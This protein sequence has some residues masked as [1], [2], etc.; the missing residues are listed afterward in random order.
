MTA[1]PLNGTRLRRHRRRSRHHARSSQT[2][3]PNHLASSRVRWLAQAHGSQVVPRP[4]RCIAEVEHARAERASQ[5]EIARIAA[6]EQRA[7]Q[8][9]LRQLRPLLEEAQRQAEREARRQR[10]AEREAQREAQREAER[11]RH[12]ADLARREAERE[13]ERQREAEREAQRQREEILRVEWRDAEDEARRQY[14]EE[15]HTNLL[16]SY[17]NARR[18][19]DGLEPLSPAAALVWEGQRET[20][21][22][23]ELREAEGL[24]PAT[25]ESAKQWAEEQKTMRTVAWINQR[26]AEQ[27]LEPLASPTSA[28][29]WSSAQRGDSPD[30]RIAARDRINRKREARSLPPF[31]RASPALVWEREDTAA[32][33]LRDANDAR[34]EQGL[35]PFGSPQAAENWMRVEVARRRVS[36]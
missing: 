29:A 23:N 31:E 17:A 27:G 33:E 7:Q 4:S 8:E 20:A 18:V 36:S 15:R 34:A 16:G 21:A 11:A 32:R 30:W 6:E 13:E 12:E 9:H 5:R 35:S 1:R 25:P 19:R 24:P 2:L 10:E 14:F 28:C 22:T 3:R 26:R